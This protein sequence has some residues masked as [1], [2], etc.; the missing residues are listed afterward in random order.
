MALFPPVPVQLHRTPLGEDCWLR[1]RL[2]PGSSSDG[3]KFRLTALLLTEETS[4]ATWKSRHW[5]RDSDEGTLLNPELPI[6]YD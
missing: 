1:V 5:R 6:A 4:A 2:L 3:T